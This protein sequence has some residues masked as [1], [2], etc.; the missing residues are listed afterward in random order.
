MTHVHALHVHVLHDHALH[1]L[2]A[3]TAPP[4]KTSV[5]RVLSDDR[6]YV[7]LSISRRLLTL[8]QPTV[9]YEISDRPKSASE[10]QSDQLLSKAGAQ[11][12][13]QRRKWQMA[14]SPCV[15]PLDG[16]YNTIV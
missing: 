2:D 5:T 9:G 4:Q 13:L 6:P 11:T 8:E 3:T 7:S 12:R 15:T 16:R 14:L 10:R 1:V